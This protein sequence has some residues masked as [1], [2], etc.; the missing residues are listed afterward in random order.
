MIKQIIVGFCW[1]LML[2]S[3]L[4]FDFESISTQFKG[5]EM[6]QGLFQD[7]EDGYIEV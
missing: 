6:S 4:G 1:G 2:L 5:S 7:F 3:M